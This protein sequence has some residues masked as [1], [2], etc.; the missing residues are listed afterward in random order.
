MKKLMID[1]VADVPQSRHH[2]P[3]CGHV[4][5][6]PLGQEEVVC[7][8]C[9]KPVTETRFGLDC[10]ATLLAEREKYGAGDMN[11]T[12]EMP[13]AYDMNTSFKPPGFRALIDEYAAVD[14]RDTVARVEDFA[15]SLQAERRDLRDVG[16]VR[17]SEMTNEEIFHRMREL[18]NRIHHSRQAGDSGKDGHALPRG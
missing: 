6:A 15:A 14:A 1:E 16:R 2:C 4:T 9:G 12:F 7:G 17:V 11:A 13:G 8:G 10:L 18:A 3:G 5:L